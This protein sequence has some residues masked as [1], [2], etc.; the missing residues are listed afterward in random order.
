MADGIITDAYPLHDGS[1]ED[2]ENNDNLRSKLYY[3]W[4]KSLRSQPLDDIRNY[5]GEKTAMYFA[6]L[7]IE[8]PTIPCRRLINF[9]PGFYTKMLFFAGI[10]GGLVVFASIWE[11]ITT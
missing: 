8:D 2:F 5:Y 11:S 9:F 4:P 3:T 6:W 10:I 1:L 7:G